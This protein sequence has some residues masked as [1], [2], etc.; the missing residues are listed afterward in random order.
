[1]ILATCT[2]GMVSGIGMLAMRAIEVGASALIV[3]FGALLLAGYLESE[4]LWM[5][6]G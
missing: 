1:M 3:A 6:T 4:R 5:F 2:T